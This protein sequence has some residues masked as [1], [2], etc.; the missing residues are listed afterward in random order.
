MTYT[1]IN[2]RIFSRIAMRIIS[3]TLLLLTG[4]A[5]SVHAEYVFLKNGTIIEGAI[6]TQTNT[7]LVFRDT[8]GKTHHIKNDQILRSIYAK[9][10]MAKVYVQK[11]NGERVVAY[12]VDENDMSYTFRNDIH[13]PKEFSISRSEVLFIADKNPSA[14]T[15]SAKTYGLT[16]SW[17]PPYD[18]VREYKI[19][20]KQNKDDQYALIA[21]S[22]RNSA[23]IKNLA[24]NTRYFIIVTAVDADGYESAPSNELSITTNESMQTANVPTIADDAS[25]I[26]LAA[27]IV[28]AYPL[29]RFADLAEPGYGGRISIFRINTFLEN[30]EIGCEAGYLYFKGKEKT[31]VSIGGKAY[32]TK[33]ATLL[34]SCGYDIALSGRMSL[35]PRIYAGVCHNRIAYRTQNEGSKISQATEMFLKGGLSLNYAVNEN[36][37]V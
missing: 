36:V 28:Y 3:I 5:F 1:Y 11:R 10:K 25:Q 22:K 8:E 26:R 6:V 17:L 7:E 15:V 27:G 20:I 30:F 29:Q 16:L 34:L 35:N 14:L 13:S 9:L 31:D 18:T 23:I 2:K 37:Y 12:L 32:S 4:V 21:S 24:G 33:T 19:Y